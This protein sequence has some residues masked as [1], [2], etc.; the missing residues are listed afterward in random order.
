MNKD[1]AN[2]LRGRVNSFLRGANLLNNL[3]VYQQK[4]L[5][6][7]LCKVIDKL[8]LPVDNDVLHLL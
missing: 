6:R 1:E 3:S 4:A 8:G 7:D 2:D 5:I